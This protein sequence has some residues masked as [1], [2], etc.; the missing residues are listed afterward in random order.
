MKVS[1]HW[2]FAQPHLKADEI[3]SFDRETRGV[4]R[5]VKVTEPKGIS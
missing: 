1:G 5:F 4:D 3:Y 2:G